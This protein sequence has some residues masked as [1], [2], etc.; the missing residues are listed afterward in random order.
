[1]IIKS[2]CL[3]DPRKTSAPNREMSY[4]DA[5]MDII[6]IAQQA[7]PKDMGQMELRR[8]QLTTLSS[9]EN[10]IPSFRRKF[11]SSPGF[12]RVTPLA[13]STA[14]VAIDSSESGESSL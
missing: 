12:S 14:I 3:G 9:D 4:R 5:A 7:K 13:S 11:S 6:S 8:A 1:M 10:R 2:D